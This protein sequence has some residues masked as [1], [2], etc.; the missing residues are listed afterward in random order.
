MVKHGYAGIPDDRRARVARSHICC[1]CHRDDCDSSC[2]CGFAHDTELT[3]PIG[4]RDEVLRLVYQAILAHIQSP[5]R[6]TPFVLTRGPAAHALANDVSLAILGI[7]RWEDILT[8][9]RETNK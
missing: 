6:A 5:I 1:F 8:R 7:T 2:G 4:Q 3:I 9:A